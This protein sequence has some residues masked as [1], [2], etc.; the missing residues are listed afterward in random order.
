MIRLQIG[1]DDTGKLDV[2][3]GLAHDLLS[4]NG[5]ALAQGLILGAT[6]ILHRD[7]GYFHRTLGENWADATYEA[8]LAVEPELTA[9]FTTEVTGRI[10]KALATVLTQTAARASDAW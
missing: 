10:W 6:L 9:E 5:D 3:L 7:G 4:E 2:V 1:D 8:V